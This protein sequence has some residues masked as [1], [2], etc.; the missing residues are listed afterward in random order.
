MATTTK[1]DPITF[2][3]VRNGLISAAMEMYWVYKRTTMLPVLYE[4]NDFGM[5]IYDDRLNL[6]AEAPG[7]PIFSGSLDDCIERT[8]AEVGGP[9]SLAEGD[10]LLNNHPYLT[11]GQPADA[12]L[13]EPIFHEGGLIGYGALRA[14]MGDLGAKGPYPTNSTE[15]YQEGILFPGVHLYRGGE[16][17]DVVI[18]ILKANSRIPA[19]TAGNVLA[20]A[21][22]LRA[23]SRVLRQLVQ[24]YGHETYY[25]AIDEL[26][27]HGE[28]VAREGIAALPDGEYLAEDYI[29][30]DG[31]T[32]D[33]PVKV[34]C[35]V[36]IDG[37]DMIID[38]TGS[39]P[40]QMGP[41]NCP[42]GYTLCTGRFSLKRLVTPDI[43][44]NGG[45][46]RALTVIAPEGS[47]FNPVPPAAT[48]I[49]WIT[50]L[51]LADMVVSALA[52]AMPD[53][54]PAESAGD[55]CGIL[56]YLKHPETGRFC[57]F[58]D[59][60]GIGHGARKGADGMSALIH[61]ISAGIEYLPAELLETRMPVVK[62]KHEL[63]QDSG[64]PG[65]FRGGLGTTASYEIQGSGVAV[66][67]SDKCTA[68]VTKGMNGGMSPPEQNA[69]LVYAGTDR[70][71]RLG[72]KSDFYLNPGDVVESR[73]TGGGGYGDPE[74]REPEKVASDVRNEYVS[75]ESAEE[76]YGVVLDADGEVDT[77]ATT[78]KR[79]QT[80]N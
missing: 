22:A 21:G 10:I 7:L 51:R 53:K 76:N 55:L 57:F 72:K 14:H 47:I 5:S 8:L 66:A 1:L 40:E 67:I 50:S 54:I 61:P 48:F 2:A 70:E 78:N 23:G 20:G 49:S 24:K 60:G 39:A 59:D 45:E 42:W 4:Y 19:E 62:L 32:P 29:D 28:R 17:Q 75:R 35:K 56:A 38:T 12:A 71:M 33:T 6:V 37:S 58:W 11:A 73:P 46:Q 77:K 43:P 13:I 15:V 79:K 31:I 26:L 3:V 80:S 64:G 36:T 68:S 41:I 25:A 65:E 30:D 44:P 69:V 9:D 52:P 18:K 63:T 34:V 27:D 74:N 16:L